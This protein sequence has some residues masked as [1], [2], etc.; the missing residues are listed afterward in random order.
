[1]ANKYMKK[2]ST[3]LAIKEMQIKMRLSFQLPPLRVTINKTT[4]KNR[5][6]VGDD[7]RKKV[8]LSIIGENVNY[9]NYYGKHYGGSLEN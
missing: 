1:M 2:C 3:S 6:N 5:T 9:C 4:N 8:S 7:A